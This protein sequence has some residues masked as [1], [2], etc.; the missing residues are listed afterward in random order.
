M[1][2][3]SHFMLRRFTITI[4]NP[5]LHCYTRVQILH[6]LFYDYRELLR[7]H[8]CQI[9]ALAIPASLASAKHRCKTFSARF[10]FIK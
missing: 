10:I 1:Q 8:E 6:I 5:K 9:E 2:I 4:L 3:Y 7:F